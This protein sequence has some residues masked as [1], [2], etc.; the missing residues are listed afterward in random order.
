MQK[1][2]FVVALILCTTSF[3]IAQV[4]DPD[5]LNYGA[6]PEEI[7]SCSFI[8]PMDA[9][10][11]GGHNDAPAGYDDF[12]L[13]AYGLVVALLWDDIPIIW[14]IKS[15]KAH[16]DYDIV[17]AP[18]IQ[19][20]PFN[21]TTVKQR[22][23]S[24]GP[25]IIETIYTERAMETIINYTQTYNI[26]VFKITQNI[27]VDVRYH[28]LDRPFVS[29]FDSSS[30]RYILIAALRAA[31]L[32]E[33]SH[34]RTM[35]KTEANSINSS[36]CITMAMEPH[37]HCTGDAY[38]DQPGATPANSTYCESFVRSMKEFINS[39]G[40][41]LSMCGGIMTYEQC[42]DDNTASHNLPTNSTFLRDYYAT[43]GY[44]RLGPPQN[45]SLCPSGFT[46]SQGGVN[47]WRNTTH[48]LRELSGPKGTFTN[49]AAD[50][51]YAQYTGK[52]AYDDWSSVESMSLWHPKLDRV[53]ND[54]G[55]I[56]PYPIPVRDP[57]G[58]SPTNLSV[59]N[60]AH[61]VIAEGSYSR[62]RIGYPYGLYY[63]G[64]SKL[65]KFQGGKGG[66]FFVLAG[67]DYGVMVRDNASCGVNNMCPSCESDA[68]C[69]T[70]GGRRL[71]MN[72][73]LTPSNRSGCSIPVNV[74]EN[75][76]C[77]IEQ[78]S[79][80]VDPCKWGTCKPQKKRNV[81]QN[82]YAS[83]WLCSCTQRL[84]ACGVCG[85]TN[86]SCT[87]IIPGT[88]D[89]VPAGDLPPGTVP[90]GVSTVIKGSL[91]PVSDP[92]QPAVQVLP[93]VLTLAEILALLSASDPSAPRFEDGNESSA[94][95]V[96]WPVVT[97]GSTVDAVT[98]DLSTGLATIKLVPPVSILNQLAVSQ[99]I[100][101]T[102]EKQLSLINGSVT[103][104]VKG[105]T[106]TVSFV[107]GPLP[108][109]S[110]PQPEDPTGL[111]EPN[112]ND[113]TDTLTDVWKYYYLEAGA[114]VQN[115]KV[116]LNI[117]SQS[118]SNVTLFL[119][120]DSLPSVSDYDCSVVGNNI[121]L[122]YTSA[123]SSGVCKTTKQELQGKWYLGVYG[124][125]EV[126]YNVEVYLEAKPGDPTQAGGNNDAPA[127]SKLLLCLI[128]V[129]IMS[130]IA[131]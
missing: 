60:R 59:S 87:V 12:N 24:G 89:E 113:V 42:D 2:L 1:S 85:G 115:W 48:G 118:N 9:T 53:Y 82:S 44:G 99:D 130:L 131:L 80:V 49:I 27:T 123:V 86:Q 126:T 7:S 117:L 77:R 114:N 29:I 28:L 64:H 109:P 63:A 102:I 121:I 5:L 57:I 68:G 39:G 90:P 125:T 91:T 71:L 45:T 18:T 22:S 110:T 92:N 79:F 16:D 56:D 83:P 20:A 11:Q 111:T 50:T 19:V 26:T 38:Q 127:T 74:C 72:A 55:N 8:I 106:V 66:N 3:V 58:A 13:A 73:V 62:D 47:S 104:V 119:R 4:Q 36:V 46:F 14:S 78:R 94:I 101:N 93:R 31:G 10:Y 122:D 30:Q 41:F 52:W 75:G 69:W 51:P 67:H 23:F 124:F 70:K 96:V 112:G 84:D 34:F 35:T 76:V 129:A 105:D 116:Y 107:I 32:V 65:Q 54:T 43:I 120:R 103:A 17:N 33:G 88:V 128:V 40:N 25:F 6:H 100:E 61:W 98:T 97:G 81:Q 108:P 15:G 21:D 95:K 37:F